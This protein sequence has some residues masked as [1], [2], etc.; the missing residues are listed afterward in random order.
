MKPIDIKYINLY[1]SNC[2]KEFRSVTID[3]KYRWNTYYCGYCSKCIALIT[4]KRGRRK[5]LTTTLFVNDEFM[6]GGT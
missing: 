3:A 2:H 5:E 4:L 1:C 6:E